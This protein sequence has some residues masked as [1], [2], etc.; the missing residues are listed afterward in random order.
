M[1]PT[2]RAQVAIRNPRRAS[3]VPMLMARALPLLL[4]VSAAA[5]GRSTG[6]SIDFTTRYAKLSIDPSTCAATHLS[7]IHI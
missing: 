5:P 7:L 4:L 3:A 6:A 2:Q 1:C